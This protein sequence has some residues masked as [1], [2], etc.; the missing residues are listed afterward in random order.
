MRMERVFGFGVKHKPSGSLV[1]PMVYATKWAALEKARSRGKDYV[2]VRVEIK[3]VIPACGT[4]CAM[5]DDVP[6][7]CKRHS[8]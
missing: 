1:L 3:E 8:P 4:G 7:F 6:V 2:T 5:V